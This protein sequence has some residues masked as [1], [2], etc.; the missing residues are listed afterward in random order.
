MSSENFD[1]KKLFIKNLNFKTTESSL[2]SILQNY[3]RIKHVKILK[4]KV[5]KKPKGMGFIEFD[6]E[7]DA[8]LILSN[9]QNMIVEGRTITLAYAKEKSETKELKQITPQ[10]ISIPKTN[11]TDKQLSKDTI[12]IYN[13]P[14]N[15]PLSKLKQMIKELLQDYQVINIHIIHKGKG[16][17]AFVTFASEEEQLKAINQ[18]NNY[19]WNGLVLNVKKAN[20][21][22]PKMNNVEPKPISVQHPQPTNLNGINH[23][24]TAPSQPQK[25]SL[26]PKVINLIL[27][28]PRIQPVR[29]QSNNKNNNINN[30]SNNQLK[31]SQYLSQI[32]SMTNKSNATVL[33]DSSIQNW[34]KGISEFDSIIFNKSKLV[35]LIQTDNDIVF[36]GF[37]SSKISTIGTKDNNYQRIKDR[38]AFVFT[39][40]D[41]NV[42]KYEIKKESSDYAFCLYEKNHSNLFQIGGDITVIKSGKV[43]TTNEIKQEAFDYHGTQKSLIGKIGKN[44]FKTKSFVVLQLN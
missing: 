19:S 6:S 12:K 36:G 25:I 32:Y 7:E 5:T 22:Q 28:K 31:Y 8:A 30:N 9:C 39:F 42:L 41:G 24:Q 3:G 34:E 20:E 23:P 13:I 17:F 44:A 40:K 11:S 27:F 35:F 18:F 10:V 26:Q 38:N 21:K 4:D 37:I 15:L 33:F 43:L 14:K 29:V 2:S 16:N 1:K